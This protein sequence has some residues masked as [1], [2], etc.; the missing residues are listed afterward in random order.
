MSPQANESDHLLNTDVQVN[1][2]DVG[3]RSH[4]K[5]YSPCDVQKDQD[6]VNTGDIDARWFSWKKLWLYTGPGMFIYQ[7]SICSTLEVCA[8]Q[9]A[10]I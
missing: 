2:T 1:Y 5:S 10:P 3:Y 7:F 6:K 9:I 8:L 4:S